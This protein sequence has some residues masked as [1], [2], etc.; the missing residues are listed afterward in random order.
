M[1]SGQ[2]DTESDAPMCAYL[3]IHMIKPRR[4]MAD[5]AWAA[6]PVACVAASMA[7]LVTV[8]VTGCAMSETNAG[9]VRN[10]EPGVHQALAEAMERADVV[11]A[12][13]Q[14]AAQPAILTG[15]KLRVIW[16]GEAR[17]ILLKIA[18]AQGLQFR[19]TGPQPALA[20]P[21]FI[22]IKSATLNE[23]LAAIGDQL[24]GRGDVV[25]NDGA[26][27]LRSKLY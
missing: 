13:T 27:E 5:L 6:R 25:L 12:K 19:V 16:K 20:M 22:D 17:E 9:V 26:L 4:Y 2:D 14:A 1:V 21:V 24:G 23:T 11:R 7:V 10:D 8:G 3:R 18:Q 15:S